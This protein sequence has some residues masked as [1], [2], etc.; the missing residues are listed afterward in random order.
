MTTA[1]R[2]NRPLRVATY[3]V[4]KGVGSD[5]RRDPE[6]ALGIIQRLGADVV[7]LQEADRRFRGRPAA[8]PP[9]RIG[10]RLDLA[11][12][13]VDGNGNGIGHH[14]NALLT[15]APLV[16]RAA[17][18]LDLPGFEP[19]GALFADLD[20]PEGPLRVAAAHLGLLKASRSDQ[21]ATLCEE[22]AA[23]APG[24]VVVLGDFNEWRRDAGH[25]DLP[26][27]FRLLRPGPSFPARQ[28]LA[29]LDGMIL[30][31]GIEA[32]AWGVHDSAA[33]RRASDH[34]PVWA[35]LRVD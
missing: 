20:T 33:A 10:D 26:A 13:A 32:L 4:H 1:A 14:G 8:I 9:E 19:R 30:G 21:V 25:L 34:L 29:A 2:N 17:R 16:A 23:Q 31:P 5:F 28:P 22:V 27:G 24:P 18:P 6:R 12:V 3:N 35:D 7:A 15:R 11:P